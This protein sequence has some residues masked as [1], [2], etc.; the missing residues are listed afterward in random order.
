MRFVVNDDDARCFTLVGWCFGMVGDPVDCFSTA[1]DVGE[2]QLGQLLCSHCGRKKW[3]RNA[4]WSRVVVYLFRLEDCF[5][6]EQHFVLLG[7]PV[8]ALVCGPV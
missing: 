7:V 4:S 3:I 1:G 6:C 5:G 2:Q 8:D